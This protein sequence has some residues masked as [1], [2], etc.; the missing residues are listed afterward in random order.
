MRNVRELILSKIKCHVV[1]L[2]LS[3]DLK[4]GIIR[5]KGNAYKVTLSY[6]GHRYTMVYHDNVKNEST[7]RDYVST[8]VREADVYDSCRDVYDFATQF[9]YTLREAYPVYKAL[10]KQSEAVHRLFTNSEL[11]YLRTIE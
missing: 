2:G 9:G 1:D 5:T 4:N 8:L 7:L 10:A 11:D 3:R 6:R